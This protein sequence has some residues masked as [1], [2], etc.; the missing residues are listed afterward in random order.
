VV[1]RA[2]LGDRQKRFAGGICEGG[3]AVSKRTGFNEKNLCTEIIRS[4]ESKLTKNKKQDKV[5]GVE[6]FLE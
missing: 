2:H 5:S 4:F 3:G 1:R 6:K